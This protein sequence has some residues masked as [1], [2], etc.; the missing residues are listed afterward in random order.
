MNNFEM[1][2]MVVTLFDKEDVITTSGGM[3]AIYSG[4]ET[5][6]DMF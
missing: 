3:E 6:M 1:P 2:K 4:I 5:E